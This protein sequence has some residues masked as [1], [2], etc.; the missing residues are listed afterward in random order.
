MNKC[1]RFLIC[2][3]V[4][5]IFLLSGCSYVYDTIYEYTGIDLDAS[6]P[7][8]IVQPI[9]SEYG[10]GQDKDAL[11]V[12]DIE[13]YEHVPEAKVIELK[14]KSENLFY[15]NLL[16]DEDK[17]I[18]SEILYILNDMSED[19][20]LSTLDN[21]VVD[22]VFNY[23]LYDHPEIYYV[24]GYT[25]VRYLVNDV[26]NT[27][28]L[29][30]TYTVSK[31]E[32]EYYDGK[33]SEYTDEFMNNIK[34]DIPSFDDYSVAK[35][36]YEYIIN[37]TDYDADAPNNQNITSVMVTGRSVCA[38]YAKTAQYLLNMCGIDTT[39]VMGSVKE[40]EAHSWNILNVDDAYYYMDVTW[41]DASYT[42]SDASSE[43]ANSLP[44]VNYNYMMMTTEE[45]L[46][47]HIFEELS[48]FPEAVSM[49][50]NYFVREG[51][52]FTEAD[53]EKL[54]N[55]FNK[56]YEAEAEYIML[57]M[58]DS[59]AYD[60]VRKHL[61]DKQKVFNYLKGNNNSVS[62]AENKDQLYMIFWI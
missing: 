62:Y 57:K 55:A 50:D 43:Y 29:S 22:K 31:K 34:S 10:E 27:L 60:S 46:E 8:I 51:L 15:Y 39:I 45:I 44:P 30:G 26:P 40:G 38:G 13:S 21:D 18:Y 25:F 33:I 1:K 5:N 24:S 37:G 47:T 32:K 53:S 54:K 2:L 12:E 9:N 19:V 61:L 14:E 20:A 42:L 36:I 16:S 17:K 49:D 41:G 48:I 58:S 56:A 11:S 52:Y 35:Y 7:D 3:L 4:I 23:V 28:T 6:K 59:E